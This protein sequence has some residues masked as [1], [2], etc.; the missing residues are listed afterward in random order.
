VVSVDLRSL[1]KAELHRHLE[2]AVRLDTIL[3][4]YRDAG[5][6][7]PEST[8]EELAARA[9]V[10]APMGSLE[11]VLGFFRVAQGAFRTYESVERISYEA[12]EDL[13]ADCVRLAEL[14]F[15]PD[16]LCSPQGLDWDRAMDAIVAG[17][18]RA[19]RDH[20]VAVGLIAIAS[21]S[22]GMQSAERT[23]AFALR[24]RERLVG[25]DLADEELSYPPRMYVGVLAPLAD[26][27]LPITAHYGE[28]TGPEFPREAIELLDVR[29][30]GHGVSVGQDPTV[31]ALARDREV[32]LEMCPTSNVRT[33]AVA[34]IEEHPAHRLLH[35]GVRVTVNTDDPGLFGIDLT[36]ELTV[37]RDKLGFDEEDLRSV[38]ANA[39][40]ASFLDD[41]TKADVW[42]RHFR[43]L[44]Q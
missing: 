42:A 26:A 39:I 38:V 35:D 44:S 14:R 17:V 36:G 33:N 18:E 43:W 12:V 24:N 23:V 6:P 25:F 5:D 2:G 29:R 4:V 9:Q 37:A 15:S 22:Y 27:G 8:S 40:E 19:A 20:D 16:F 7:L 28:S 11:E 3:D 21:R 13:A 30:L 41:G 34:S 32:T 10:R 31:A 1:P